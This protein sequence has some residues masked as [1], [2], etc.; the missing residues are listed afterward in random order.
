MSTYYYIIWI[1][2]EFEIQSNPTFKE[3]F[4]PLH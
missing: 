1:E 3:E 4:R 2:L